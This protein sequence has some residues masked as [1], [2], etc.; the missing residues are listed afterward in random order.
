MAETHNYKIIYCEFLDHSSSL[1]WTTNDDLEKELPAVIIKCIGYLVKETK[2]CIW[3]ASSEDT[4]F[5]TV[6]NIFCIIKKNITKRKYI[7]G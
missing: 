3:I 1:Q 2:D 7:N 6:S 4:K 5:K